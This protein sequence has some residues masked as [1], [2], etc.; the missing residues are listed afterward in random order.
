MGIKTQIKRTIASNGT[1]VNE[2][3]N[4]FITEKIALGLSQAT[5]DSY[6]GSFARFMMFIKNDV[7]VKSIDK[8]TLENWI[9]SLNA[10]KV[11][12]K[13]SS[14]NHYLRAIR[15]FLYWC[16]NEEQEYI[17]KP[18]K[19]RLVKE[20]E[21]PPKTFTNDEQIA[22]IAKPDKHASFVEVRSWVITQFVL[23]S[24]SRASTIINIKIEDVNLTNREIIQMH[25][26]NNKAHIIPLSSDFAKILKQYIREF[27]SDAKSSDYLFCDIGG[28]RLSRN[29]LKLSFKRFCWS[30]GVNKTSIHGLRHSFATGYIRNKGDTFSLQKILGHS[31]LNMTRRYVDLVV[32]DLKADH[33]NRSQFSSL[34][35]N[36]SRKQVVHRVGA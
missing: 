30:R 15:T 24:G 11:K 31:T 21:T 34:K 23:D 13:Q 12:I 36:T 25:T 10:E 27:R 3:Y 2:A 33:D 1:S 16:M 19:I 20:Q 28:N 18:Y 29:A 35:S 32:D 17:E 6:K 5:I 14:I 9:K 26:K 8:K 7:P 22:L 4:E